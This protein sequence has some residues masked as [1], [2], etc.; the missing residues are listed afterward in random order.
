MSSGFRRWTRLVGT[1]VAA[2]AALA[3]AATRLPSDSAAASP[4]RVLLLTHNTFYNHS[5]LRAIEEL[6][7]EWGATAGFT[8][9]SLQGYRQTLSCTTQSRVHR[10]WSICR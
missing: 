10:T 9:I 5:N 8:V 2:V 3:A 6:L 7:P 4:K 1:F